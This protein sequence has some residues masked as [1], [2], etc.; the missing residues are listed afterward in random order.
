[1]STHATGTFEVKSWDEKTWDGKPH[2]EVSGAKLTHARVT[3]AYHGDIEGEGTREYL[4]YYREDG[5]AAIVGLEQIVG[6][7]GGRSGSFIVRHSGTFE[8]QVVKGT[9]IV[10]PG[11]GTGDLRG[12]RGEG[13]VDLVGH[14]ER[15]PVTL[16]YDFE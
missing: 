1:M 12:L 10:I 15:Y 4:M 5:T 13:I 8:D 11:S 16:D 7:L 6:S 3:C 2:K 9:M 14:L